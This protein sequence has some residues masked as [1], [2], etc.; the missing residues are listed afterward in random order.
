V[1]LFFI[2]LFPYVLK[3]R[4]KE[5]SLI[6][7]KQVTTNKEYKISIQEFAILMNN[8]C[9]FLYK[10]KMG[11]PYTLLELD[12]GYVVVY[13]LTPGS[14]HVPQIK[15]V[16]NDVNKTVKVFH[17]N[18]KPTSFVEINGTYTMSNEELLKSDISD[19]PSLH[20]FF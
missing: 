16:L 17:S 1:L 10:N 5:S 13:T 4:K 19:L 15:G 9:E 7:Q 18:L 2:L 12:K 3:I 11:K 6:V 14:P 20:L 8:I